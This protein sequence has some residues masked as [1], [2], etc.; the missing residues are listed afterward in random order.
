M[1]AKNG[2]LTNKQKDLMYRCWSIIDAMPIYICD[3]CASMNEIRNFVD[4]EVN[5]GI[6]LID[7]LQLIDIGIKG[8]NN[9]VNNIMNPVQ[10]ISLI[11]YSLKCLAKEKKIPIIVCLELSRALELRSNK[12]PT[13]D[14]LNFSYAGAIVEDADGIMFIYRDSYYSYNGDNAELILAKNRNGDIGTAYVKFNRK[15]FTFE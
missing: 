13:L 1:T 4:K 15:K 3:T 10:R 6:L 7:Y 2:N 12:R 8:D 9:M 5:D 14:D 11:S